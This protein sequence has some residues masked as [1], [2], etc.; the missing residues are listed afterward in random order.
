MRD[1]RDQHANSYVME[2]LEEFM[3]YSVRMAAY[4]SIGNSP[5]SPTVSDTTRESG[6]LQLLYSLY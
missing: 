5:Y 6:T 2:N 4:N 1:V 3:T